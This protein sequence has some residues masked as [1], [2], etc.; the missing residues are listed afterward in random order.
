MNKKDL[1]IGFLAGILIAFI[2]S[3]LF[4][5]L[6]TDSPFLESFAAIKKNNYLGKVI[7]LGTIIDLFF[8]AFLI[9][10]N[11]ESMAKGVIA[12]VLLLALYTLI[13]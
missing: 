3:V 13:I 2:G 10:K 8:F 4:I 12:A 6:F 5:L 11:K 9:K 1:F 7:T